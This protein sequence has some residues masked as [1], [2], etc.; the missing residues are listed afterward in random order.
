MSIPLKHTNCRAL[1][2]ARPSMLLQVLPLPLPLPLASFPCSIPLASHLRR[3]HH[4][5]PPKALQFHK[6]A[7]G[8]NALDRRSVDVADLGRRILI[9]RPAAVHLRENSRQKGSVRS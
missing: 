1:H 3:V 2:G 7:K 5:K 6:H 4:R 9:S 8:L